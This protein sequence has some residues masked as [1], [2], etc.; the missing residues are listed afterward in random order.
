MQRRSFIRSL[1]AAGLIPAAGCI[2]KTEEGSGDLPSVNKSLNFGEKHD[3]QDGLTVEVNTPGD[4]HCRYHNMPGKDYHI[5]DQPGSKI[6]FIQIDVTNTD[7]ES[8]VTAPVPDS[9]RLITGDKVYDPD[10][11][12][13]LPHQTYESKELKP[14]ESIQGFLWYEVPEKTSLK[15]VTLIMVKENGNNVGW[16][17]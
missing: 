8:R 1:A 14:G 5:C 3:T 9:F 15:H 4:F 10:A 7:D 6:E 11:A 12:K 13:L 17:S 16:R 2:E